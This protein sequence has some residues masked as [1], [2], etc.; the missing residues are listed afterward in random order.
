MSK[1]SELESL[2]LA[3]ARPLSVKKLAEFLTI[4][5]S[6]VLSAATELNRDYKEREA[7]CQLLI[8]N[9]QIQLVTGSS[10]SDL[11]KRFLKDEETGELSKPSLETLTIIAYR[12]PITK[13]ELEQIR[14]VNCSLIL[15]NLLI[16]GLIEASEDK[17]KLTTVYG[18][19]LDFLKFLGLATVAEL[20]DYEQLNSDEN[21][22]KILA[23]PA[24]QA[25]A[26][27]PTEH[28]VKVQVTEG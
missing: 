26:P 5:E 3:A 7:G 10:N 6:E 2:L 12:Q 9:H 24:L 22:Q 1:K 15:R 21:L 11:V 17:I 23:D 8:N 25:I 20:P 16:R 18:V 14:G 13:A 28:V 19:T 27:E 4:D